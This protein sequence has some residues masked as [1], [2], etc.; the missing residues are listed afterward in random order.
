MY[1][2]NE[3]KDIWQVKSKNVRKYKKYL[4]NKWHKLLRRG[5]NKKQYAGNEV[6][7]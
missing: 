6:Y 4:K 7:W 3:I 2:A 1:K 5:A